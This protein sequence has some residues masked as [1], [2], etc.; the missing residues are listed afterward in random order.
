MSGEV[1]DVGETGEILIKGPQ[2]MLGY[3]KNKEATDKT[4][5]K[6]GWLYTGLE[7]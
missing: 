2:V 7:S 6:D 5:D 4:I 1:L 3:L